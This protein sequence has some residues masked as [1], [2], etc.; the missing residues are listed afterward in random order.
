MGRALA[1]VAQSRQITLGITFGK[2]SDDQGMKVRGRVQLC[3]KKL[4]ECLLT[5]TNEIP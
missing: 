2:G 3:K 1:S 5:F 4:R